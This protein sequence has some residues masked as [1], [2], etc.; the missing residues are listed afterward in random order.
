MKEFLNIVDENNNFTGEIAENSYVHDNGI[1]HREVACWLMNQYGEILVQK[2]ALT[3][4]CAP[5]KWDITAGHVKTNELEEDAMVREIKE[6]LGIKIDKNQLKFLMIVKRKG[7]TTKNNTFQYHYF[8]YTDKKIEEYN[9][10][11]EEVD[12]IKYISLEDLKNILLQKN[13]D[14]TFAKRKYMKDIYKLLL[15]KRN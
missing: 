9:I 4:R 11:K 10:Q 15:E 5:G 7:I 12:K 13:E 14:Y 6:E 1:W 3:K 8:A 2:R